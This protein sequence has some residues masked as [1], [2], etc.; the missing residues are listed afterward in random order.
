MPQEKNIFTSPSFSNIFIRFLTCFAAGFL[1]FI[2]LGIV[3]LA[4]WGIVGETL[5]ATSSPQNE[6][7]INISTKPS[8]PL[9]LS[10]ITLAIFLGTLVSSLFYVFLTTLVEEKYDFRSTALTHV[11]FANLWVLFLI[12]PVYLVMNSFLGP[13]GAKTAGLLHG[14]IMAVFS[15]FVLEILNNKKY[16]LVNLYGL[17]VGFILFAIC[18]TLILISQ[19]RTILVFLSFPLLFGFLGAGNS[20]MEIF[21]SWLYQIYGVDFLNSEKGFYGDYEK[22]EK[23]D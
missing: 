13:D 9:F 5:T 19:N 15:F 11:F 6:F 21:Y 23:N 3:I 14:I 1:G 18:A 4:S 16:L 12:L 10:I 22:E 8:H 2:I 7:G 20:L 17:I